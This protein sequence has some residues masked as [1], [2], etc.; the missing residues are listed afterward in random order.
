MA[1]EHDVRGLAE[2]SEDVLKK[3]SITEML[4]PVAR[5]FRVLKIAAKI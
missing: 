3:V 2:D 1:A 5:G 4:N